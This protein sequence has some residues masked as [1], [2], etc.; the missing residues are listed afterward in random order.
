MGRNLLAAGHQITLFD[1][2]SEA[3]E[4][5]TKAGATIATRLRDV[6]NA[7][8]VVTALSSGRGL[9]ELVLGPNGV[10]AV[11]PAGTVHI[12]MSTI[13]VALSR[14]LAAA[15]K[16]R[17]QRYIAAPVFGGPGAAAERELCIFAGG[18]AG[19]I[20]YCQTLFDAVA[21]HTIEVGEDPAE[22]NLLQLCALGLIGLLV[23]SLGEVVAL[24]ERGGIVPQRFLKLMSDYLFG[25]GLHASYGALL[26]GRSTPQR[27]LT[28]MQA[29]NNA[30]LLLESARTLGAETPLVNL[31]LDRL[32]SLEQ[33]GM[34]HVDW[35]AHSIAPLV[36]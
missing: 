15:H 1:P 28:V 34:G 5:F 32:L 14:R 7:D 20:S 30:R 36:G 6:C 10:V 22:A 25:Q 26:S 9:E 19:L 13:S 24:G 18:H 23:E 12:S 2:A 27:L 33:A 16:Q 17:I 11:M 4:D 21:R 8:A 35:L 29:Q 31:L 3:A